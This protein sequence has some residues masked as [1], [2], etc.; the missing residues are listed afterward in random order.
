MGGLVGG[1]GRLGTVAVARLGG[2]SPRLWIWPDPETTPVTPGE[3]VIAIEYPRPNTI[4]RR[5]CP[6]CP[7]GFPMSCPRSR[8]SNTCSRRYFFLLSVKQ[9]P[10][11]DRLLRQIRNGTM[12]NAK[13]LEMNRWLSALAADVILAHVPRS[14]EAQMGRERRVVELHP[15]GAAPR[16]AAVLTDSWSTIEPFIDTLSEPQQGVLRLHLVEGASYREVAERLAIPLGT[17][18]SRVARAKRRIRAA[19]LQRT[20]PA[21]GFPSAVRRP[22]ATLMRTK[23]QNIEL[24]LALEPA[25]KGE[26]RSAGIEGT[27]ARTARAEPERPAAGQQPSMEAVVEPGNLKKALARVRRNK[28]GARRRRHDRR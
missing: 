17:V 11:V 26:A 27:E 6:T 25:A 23:R 7:T 13:L 8:K 2:A 1:D 19:A 21:G 28:G 24:E 22:P 10:A 12:D 3:Y 9:Q 4:L 20:P 16:T 5:K 15:Y 14:A 18:H